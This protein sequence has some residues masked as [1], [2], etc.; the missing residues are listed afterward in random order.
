MIFNEELLPD[1]RFAQL[2]STQQS[3]IIANHC[4]EIEELIRTASSRFEAER[5]SADACLRFENECPSMLV[6]HALTHRVEEFITKYWSQ[7]K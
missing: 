1:D 3:E 2:N 5:I 4:A 6:R 7:K